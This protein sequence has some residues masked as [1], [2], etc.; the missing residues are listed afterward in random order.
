MMNTIDLLFGKPVKITEKVSLHVP[1][2]EDV[3]Y[4]EKYS[5]YTQV[6]VITT[7]EMFS[8]L[9][10]VDELEERFETVW[11]MAFDKEGSLIIGQMFGGKTG[12][13]VIIE[14]LSYWTKLDVESF[15]ALSSGRIVNKDMDWVIDEKVFNSI[16]ECIKEIIGYEQDLDLIA[17]KDMS[18]RQLDIWQK[19]YKGRVRNR[20]KNSISFADK[21]MILSISMD[22]YIPIGDIREMTIYHFNKLYEGLSEKESY[23]KQWEVKMSPKFESDGNIKHWKEKFK[24]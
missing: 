8:S 5:S 16:G 11:K 17:P 3:A 1:T 18:E 14:A 2:V 19:T 20:Q 10:E 6:F 15:Q 24:I 12:T 9:A 21:I 22:A 23:E 7:R 4:T 13:E